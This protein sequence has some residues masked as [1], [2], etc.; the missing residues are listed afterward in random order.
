MIVNQTASGGGD[1]ITLGNL[2]IGS[3]VWIPVN[4]YAYY[5]NLVELT[6]SNEDTPFVVVHK[7]IP[8]DLY[9]ES[10]NGVWLL[11]F[12]AALSGKWTTNRM[13]ADSNFDV[14]LNTTFYSKIAPNIQPLIK[15][16]KIPY[17]NGT[18]QTGASGL[19]RKVFP[20]N[21]VEIGMLEN[22][23]YGAKLDWFGRDDT[24][25]SSGKR[26]A[27]K[28]NVN[29]PS[30]WRRSYSTTGEDY[31]P[32][33]T[34]NN[35]V[36]AFVSDTGTSGTVSY[37]NTYYASRPAFVMSPDVEVTQDGHVVGV[38]SPIGSFRVGSI[39][40]CKVGGVRT[41]FRVMHCGNPSTSLYDSSCDGVWLLMVNGYQKM[42]W[43]SSASTAYGSSTVHTYLN[44]EFLALLDIK[45]MVKHVRIPYLSDS[46][47]AGAIISGSDGL[48]TQVFLPSGAELGWKNG[49]YSS[50]KPFP[51]DG[52][53][54]AYCA[55]GASYMT[56]Y[57]NDVK[58][59]WW[60]RSPDP[61]TSGCV[62]RVETDGAARS[63]SPISADAKSTAVRPMLILPSDTMVDSNG[64]IV[65]SA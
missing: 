37:D 23:S 59:E 14:K 49:D 53:Q 4:Q 62:Y 20:L 45:N 3:I 44:N 35:S 26:I 65:V 40:Y 13:Y 15:E 54:L 50:Y 64:D 32:R 5:T 25:D 9:D 42:A 24:A 39:V 7:G 63:L 22:A 19:A 34:D 36:M 6:A 28:Y 16:V 56:T 31:W 47:S 27:Y 10:C 61:T 41:A 1:R 60:T 33:P 43:N 55:A 2:P 48:L 58:V 21:K 51:E 18:Y 52:S 38:N 29:D 8:S 57:M 17:Y 12:W 30:F 11:S 46:G